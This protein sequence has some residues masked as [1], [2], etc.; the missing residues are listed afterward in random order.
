MNWKINLLCFRL[1]QYYVLCEMSVQVCACV[2][3]C[4]QLCAQAECRGLTLGVTKV[5][6]KAPFYLY[7]P[8]LTVCSYTENSKPQGLVSVPT[9]VRSQVLGSKLRFM[10]VQLGLYL[11]SHLISPAILFSV[12]IQHYIYTLNDENWLAYSTNTHDEF[13][14]K[15]LTISNEKQ[16]SFQQEAWVEHILLQEQTSVNSCLENQF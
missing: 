10:L 4:M 7:S 16:N 8:S 3:V 15:G 9:A 5:S 11:L 14:W 13:P 2:H 12:K 1:L 6:T